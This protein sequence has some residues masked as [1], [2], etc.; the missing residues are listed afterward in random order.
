M[1]EPDFFLDLLSISPLCIFRKDLTDPFVGCFVLVF[2]VDIP[3]GIETKSSCWLQS[4][5]SALSSKVPSLPGS[6]HPTHGAVCPPPLPSP[7]A[8]RSVAPSQRNL[9]AESIHN[10]QPQHFFLHIILC[11]KTFMTNETNLV[12]HWLRTHLP[13]HCS[14][15]LWTCYIQPPPPGNSITH[16]RTLK[17]PSTPASYHVFPKYWV[18]LSTLQWPTGSP[19][20]W[21][22]TR[23]LAAETQFVPVSVLTGRLCLWRKLWWWCPACCSL[24]CQPDFCLPGF[25]LIPLITKCHRQKLPAVE[26]EEWFGTSSWLKS[27]MAAQATLLES[28]SSSAKRRGSHHQDHTGGQQ[29]R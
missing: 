15:S 2:F 24:F 6:R 16:N 13:V 19:L 5:M 3:R 11:L 23:L 7:V 14:I 21:L 17:P 9:C 29:R 10:I 28:T 18:P 26:M 20:T 4:I 27:L 12:I 1:S 8:A 22:Q 25:T